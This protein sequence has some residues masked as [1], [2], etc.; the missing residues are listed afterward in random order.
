M[1]SS[2]S[3]G[4]ARTSAGQSPPRSKTASEGALGA[5]CKRQG[6]G[7]GTGQQRSSVHTTLCACA[8]A[9]NHVLAF[10]ER[11]GVLESARDGANDG[12]RGVRGAFWW[13][14]DGAGARLP[15]HEVKHR[16]HHHHV[17]NV[18]AH[19]V[20]LGLRRRR[21]AG[22]GTCHD[23]GTCHRLVTCNKQNSLYDPNP[24]IARPAFN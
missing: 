16:P 4:L 9:T 1:V 20:R 24:V 7:Q 6:A 22:G 21:A 5:R 2:R 3:K 18:A 11:A 23:F 19:V 12:V 8:R 10:R 14:S 15:Q 17:D 13:R